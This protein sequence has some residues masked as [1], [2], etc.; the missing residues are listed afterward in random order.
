[1]A[2][3][4]KNIPDHLARFAMESKVF[5]IASCVGDDDVN[6]SPKGVTPLK[7]I[8][9]KTVVYPD[10]HGSGNQT[11]AHLLQG[12]KATLVFMSFDEKPLILR[13][14][15]TGRVVAAGSDEFNEIF[16][17]H[18]PQFDGSRFRQVF[19]F[20]VY[21]VQTS[22]GYGVPVMEYKGDRKNRPYFNELFGQ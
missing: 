5:F 17:A 4:W 2:R 22:C 16:S 7:V 3:E 8:D 9:D 14:Y 20:N 21:R 10:Y 13:F 19:I 15:C 18:Y 12:G 6:L 1:M 11:A